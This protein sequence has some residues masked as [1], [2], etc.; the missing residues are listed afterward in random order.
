MAAQSASLHHKASVRV[1][2]FWGFWG[3]TNTII[4]ASIVTIGSW[5]MLYYSTM[6]FA[7]K[8]LGSGFGIH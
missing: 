5:G 4:R 2:G 3:F 8:S 1:E 6:K 7:T